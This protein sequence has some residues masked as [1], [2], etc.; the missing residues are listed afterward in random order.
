MTSVLVYIGY[1]AWSAYRRRQ[2]ER[3][4]VALSSAGAARVKAYSGYAK[5]W[6]VWEGF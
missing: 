1:W 5:R 2:A 6:E 3:E 4:R